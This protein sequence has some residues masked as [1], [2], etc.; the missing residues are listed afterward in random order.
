MLIDSHCHLDRLDLSKHGDSLSA[1]LDDARSVG[2]KRFL[3]VCISKE[4]KDQVVSIAREHEGVFASVGVHPSDVANSSVDKRTL[5]DWAKEANVVAIGETGL[6]YHY[7]KENKELQL[8]SF[9]VHLLAASECQLPV[10]VHTREAQ[11][12]TLDLIR[13]YANL[14]TAGVLHCFTE[15][16]EM[17][18]AAIDMNFFISISGIV[19]FKN[20]AQ[21]REVAAKVPSDR[22]LIETDSPYLAPVPFRGKPNQPKYVHEVAKFVADL[23]GVSYEQLLEQTASNFFNLFKKAC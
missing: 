19:T 4:N 7:G 8:E 22:L 17:A 23:R 11:Q 12:D 20:A 15:S 21:L 3:C 14:E 16:W 1:L 9:T 10:I 2:V 6:D 5:I 18:Q 13:R